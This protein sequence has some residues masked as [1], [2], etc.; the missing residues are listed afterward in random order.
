[1]TKVVSYSV[2]LVLVELEHIQLDAFQA[3]R[4]LAFVQPILVAVDR[5]LR[6]EIG[7][8]FVVFVLLDIRESLDCIH[9]LDLVVRVVLGSGDIEAGVLVVDIGAGAVGMGIV[10]GVVDIG[11]VVAVGVVD[12][13]VVDIEAVPV[14]LLLVVRVVRMVVL[15]GSFVVLVFLA[16]VD[17]EA[18]LALPVVEVLDAEAS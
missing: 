9:S 1:M 18:L 2:G 12:I 5:L 6:R 11:A 17:I 4:H 3:F 8:V 7:L 13:G 16:E 15:V 10:V 14:V